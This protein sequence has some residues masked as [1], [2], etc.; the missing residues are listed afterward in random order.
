MQISKDPIWIDSELSLNELSL[1]LA[2]QA[3]IAIDTEFMRSDTYYPIAGLIQVSDGLQTYLIDPLAINDMSA[4][5]Q[6]LVNE[7]VVKVLHSCS[8]DLEVFARLLSV[9]PQ[10]IFDTQI[11]AAFAGIGYSMGYAALIKNL[12]NV[13]IPKDE[14][15][16]DWLQRPLSQSQIQY[17]ALDVAHMLIVYGKI[18]QL[19]KDKNRWQWAKQECI[20]L[21]AAAKTEDDFSVAYQKVGLAFKL[22]PNELAILRDLCIWR[23]VEA[24]KRDIPRNRLAKENCLWE[25]ARKKPKTAA[26]LQKIHE[27]PSRTVKQD[28]VTLL[29]IVSDGLTSGESTWPSRVPPPLAPSDGD[30]LKAL[31][32]A[33]RDQ[34]EQYEL[35]T[36][37]LIRK[38]EYEHIVR[39]GHAGQYEL[40]ERLLG[41]RYQV[42]GDALLAVTKQFPIQSLEDGES[43]NPVDSYEQPSS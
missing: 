7:K 11:G 17:A 9:V 2:Q 10:P 37:I 21:I 39:S 19:L 32:Q 41:W 25:I 3:A 38:K 5:A 33:V 1:R 16:S 6:L 14:T 40:P 15:R 36:E 26:E 28:A 8:E 34:A 43:I 20:D 27:L 24:R 18:K 4:F 12:L 30:L 22:R 35:P 23:E 42:I 31:K 13:E 29:T